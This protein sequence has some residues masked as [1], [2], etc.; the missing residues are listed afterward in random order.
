MR[1]RDIEAKHIRH[2][3]GGRIPK[4]VV[5]KLRRDA[6][7]K[8]MGTLMG[9]WDNMQPNR[10]EVVLLKS[11]VM[12]IEVMGRGIPKSWGEPTKITKHL[13]YW[14]NISDSRPAEVVLSDNMWTH[15]PEGSYFVSWTNPGGTDRQHIGDADKFG[16]CVSAPRLRDNFDA[17]FF[18]A[19]EDWFGD[20]NC[21]E[22]GQN[23]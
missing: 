12:M 10:V 2:A 8:I 16:M 18:V 22:G 13:Y 9:R 20:W 19:D 17:P 3:L 21:E 5:D 23:L 4:S 6:E 14:N 1:R 7:M 15:L 11:T